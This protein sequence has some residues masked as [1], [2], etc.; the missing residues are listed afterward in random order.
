M[1]YTVIEHLHTLWNDHHGKS[2]NHLSPYKVITVLLTIFLM[3]C[4]TSLRLIYF[5]SG[6]LYLLIP[7]TYF[8]YSG[9]ESWN[10]KSRTLCITCCSFKF[11]SSLWNLILPCFPLS[12]SLPSF[13]TSGNVFYVPLFQRTVQIDFLTYLITM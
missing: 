9:V 13:S 3:L 2:S 8:V 4:V 5:I 7:F 11:R 1:Y 12:S 6:G 10:V